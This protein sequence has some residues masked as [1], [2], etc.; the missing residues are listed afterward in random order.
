MCHVSGRTL[1]HMACHVLRRTPLHCLE[2]TVKMKNGKERMCK[3]NVDKL[4]C[5]RRC[6]STP[7]HR[8]PNKKTSSYDVPFCWF[9]AV[10]H[11]PLIEKPFFVGNYREQYDKFAQVLPPVNS[12]FLQLTFPFP[13]ELDQLN[14]LFQNKFDLFLL[15]L[16]GV[17]I[18]SPCSSNKL[19]R[20]VAIKQDFSCKINFSRISKCGRI[21]PEGV[22]GANVLQCDFFDANHVWMIDGSWSLGPKGQPQSSGQKFSSNFNTEFPHNRPP[23]PR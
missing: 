9:S 13:L 8:K 20:G 16:I 3:S 6:F 15:N 2:V 17:C 23:C 7:V 11:F 5:T 12:N 1:Q 19:K 18:T 14:C 22:K 4:A 21:F 10:F